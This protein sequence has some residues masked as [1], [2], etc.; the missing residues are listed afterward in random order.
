MDSEQ[1]AQVLDRL[2]RIELAIAQ[3]TQQKMVKDWYTTADLAGIL[4]KSEFTV[5]EW[6]RL[7]RVNSQKRD[8]GRGGTQEWIV[9]HVE[10]VR[11]QNF[12]LLPVVKWRPQR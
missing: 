10:L 4:M 11:I 12:G 9:S 7:G 3:L 2:E 8:C 5:R 6:C 1:I